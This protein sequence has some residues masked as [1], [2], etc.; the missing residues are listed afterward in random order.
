MR[1]IQLFLVICFFLCNGQGKRF[2]YE[3][4]YIP[5]KLKPKEVSKETMFLDLYSGKSEFYSYQKYRIDSTIVSEEKKGR[6]SMPPNI[7]V[8]SYRVIKNTNTKGTNF[9]AKVEYQ[10]YNISDNRTQQ[11]KISSETGKILGYQIQK[12]ETDFGG[13]HWIAWFSKDIPVPDG[14]YKFQGL[15]GLILKL[16]D[17]TESHKFLV[18]GISSLKQYID[19]PQ[20]E[21][22][23]VIKINQATYEKIYIE[24]RNDPVK[25]LRGRMPDQTDDNGNF[26]SGAEALRE[27]EKA[28]RKKIDADNNIIE[29]DMLKK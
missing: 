26:I 24:K 23:P 16:E 13:R 28:F 25:N 29:I 4:Q 14:P 2:I 15:P 18:K 12:A 17:S 9:I 21:E 27:S 11:W 10:L 6:P 5:N 7:D 22:K 19:Y 3:Y 20:I 8:V 1:V